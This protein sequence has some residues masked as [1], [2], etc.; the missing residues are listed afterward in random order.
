MQLEKNTVVAQK[1]KRRNLNRSL[2]SSVFVPMLGFIGLSAQPVS[3]QNSLALEEVVV[4]AQKREES[5]QDVPISI[6]VVSGNQILEQGYR[7]MKDVADFLPN[8][9]ISK[10]FQPSI[11][12]RGIS[13]GTFNTTFEQAVATFVDG[14]YRGR[15]NAV[16]DSALMDVDRIEILKGPQP[17]FFGQSAIA[18]AISITTR[19]PSDEWEGYAVG[20]VGFDSSYQME[21]A[22]GGPVTDTLGIRLALRKDETENWLENYWGGDFNSKTHAGRVT[23]AWDPSDTFSL[24]G[25]YSK[26]NRKDPQV[27]QNV[28][29]DASLPGAAS[30]PCV[31]ALMDDR[32][33]GR[34]ENKLN[35]VYSYGGA[36]SGPGQLWNPVS[37]PGG[38]TAANL[39]QLDIFNKVSRPTD[40][41]TSTLE[42]N[43]DVGDVTLTSITGYIDLEVYNYLDLEMSPY[44]L[45]VTSNY[46][47]SDQ[48]SQEFRITSNSSSPIQWMA[49]VYWQDSNLDFENQLVSAFSPAAG[50]PFPPYLMV[51]YK[52]D[53]EWLSAFGTL[54]WAISEK[55]SLQLGVRY[56]KVEKN[57]KV[58]NGALTFE[59]T[60]GD[61]LV[62]TT[63]DPEFYDPTCDGFRPPP[64]I[65]G[66]SIPGELACW[67]K[68]IDDTSTNPLVAVNYNINDDVMVYAKYAEG[69]KAGGLTVGMNVVTTVEE[70]IYDPEDAKTFEVGV[71][72]TLLDGRIRLNADLFYTKYTD[73][74]VTTYD[75]VTASFLIDNAGKSTSQGLE[76]D[77]V[78]QATENLQLTAA[79]ALLDSEYDEYIGNCSD[80]DVLAGTPNKLVSAGVCTSV[81][82][83]IDRAG[84]KLRNAPEW[85]ASL[86]FQYE[87]SVTDSMLITV[88]GEAFY[89]DEYW[90]AT[91]YDP[92]GKRDSYELINLT[93]GLASTADTWSVQLYGRNITDTQRVTDFGPAATNNS[94]GAFSATY[95]RGENYGVLL[96]YNFF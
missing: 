68:S 95:T 48:T 94:A 67:D 56:S 50:Q 21:A 28:N 22:Y 36:I 45:A 78:F 72:S 26:S 31:Q 69:F 20:D 51:K 41:E 49:G 34:S 14:V 9:E 74:Q 58:Q 60:D 61:G 46:E 35:N 39:T 8:V 73:Q 84:F 25:R 79:L 15:P 90:A 4:T 93:V 59:D 13:T 10:G 80:G 12:V 44:A 24:V 23:I 92:R 33:E 6:Q 32:F 11:T 66:V 89:S 42:M 17:T 40:L 43:W 62:D 29:C 65:P 64:G 77:M 71:K 27:V 3:A 91:D 30:S 82:D 7:D 19:K 1:N 75:S 81:Q 18:G 86:G 96:R 52:E 88:N 83:P 85:S 55:L 2:L 16:S 5:L 63:S 37:N 38:Y 57:G 76:A 87:H 47:N 53:A 70:L 54:D